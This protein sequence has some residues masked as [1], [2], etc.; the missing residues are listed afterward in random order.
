MKPSI[1]EQIA[2]VRRAVE[3]LEYTDDTALRHDLHAPEVAALDAVLATLSQHEASEAVVRRARDVVA[4]IECAPPSTKEVELLRRSVHGILSEALAALDT[5]EPV[6][7]N[8][9][10]V[11]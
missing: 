5:A 8:R 7:D 1:A 3:F 4:A 2:A 9:N 10:D 11:V 6:V